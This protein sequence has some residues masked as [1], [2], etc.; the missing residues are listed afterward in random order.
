MENIEKENLSNILK[1]GNRFKQLRKEAGYD[2]QEIF[3]YD[4]DIN[5]VQYWRV[6]KGSNITLTTFF[7]LLEIHKITPEEFF[8]DFT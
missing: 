3:A 6:E 1:V 4:K 8:K 7:K 5:R 2:S